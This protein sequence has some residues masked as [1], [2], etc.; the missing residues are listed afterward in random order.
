MRKQCHLSRIAA[1]EGMSVS[2]EHLR[3]CA[4]C[5]EEQA[6]KAQIAS[7]AE[8][9]PWSPPSPETI[10]EMRNKLLLSPRPALPEKRFVWVRNAVIAA[11]IAAALALAIRA[12]RLFEKADAARVT[13]VAGPDTRY[14]REDSGSDRLQRVRLF[15]GSIRLQ[16]EP[17]LEGKKLIVATEDAEVEVHGTVFDVVAS[18]EKLSRVLV[19]SGLVEVRRKGEAAVMLRAGET[20]PVV[21]ERVVL[22]P[23]VAVE[24]NVGSSGLELGQGPI[25]GS[26]PER[27]RD[28]ERIAQERAF[29]EA[30]TALSAGETDRAVELFARAE[31]IA[32]RAQLAEDAAYGR[33]VALER[34]GRAAEAAEAMK[35]FLAH[36]PRAARADEVSVALG[37][38]LVEAGDKEEARLLFERA[39]TS[40]APSVRQSA[41]RGVERLA[42]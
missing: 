23:S 40:P 27:R 17:L 8:K 9:L 38:L 18:A 11:G 34:A 7:V 42:Q 10:Q 3:S 37:W 30:W 15:E 25:L 4:E 26:E 22:E 24:S 28:S 21:V 35:R 29:R 5:A 2:A 39:R 13:I 32:P 12:P 6:A 16:V 33:A 36:H 1:L 14:V 19:I 31:S 20:W 41:E